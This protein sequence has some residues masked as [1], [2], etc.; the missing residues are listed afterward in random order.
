[1]SEINVIARTQ[2][3]VVEPSSRSVSVINEGPP[4]PSGPVGPVGPAGPGIWEW[5]YQNTITAPPATGVY[6]M[7]SVTVE[8]VTQIWVNNQDWNNIARRNMLLLATPGDELY[9]QDFQNSDAWVRFNISSDDNSQV[10]YVTFNVTF[11]S[12]GTMPLLAGNR[13]SI[14]VVQSHVVGAGIPAG[15]TTGQ[16]LMKISNADFDFAWR[17]LPRPT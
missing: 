5:T 14:G 2:N 12:K 9:V 1:M 15:G 3:I 17:D 10:N 6:R 16:V 8:S 7:N 4:G 11:K 13:S